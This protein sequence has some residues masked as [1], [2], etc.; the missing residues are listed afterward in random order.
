MSVCFE[1][2]CT[3]DSCG[4]CLPYIL[5]ERNVFF[6][7]CFFLMNLNNVFKIFP[8]KDPGAERSHWQWGLS[9]AKSSP[10]LEVFMI[11][12]NWFTRRMCQARWGTG[13]DSVWN[14]NFQKTMKGSAESWQ[15]QTLQHHKQQDQSSCRVLLL[16]I[17]K[18]FCF[19]HWF[20]KLTWCLINTD[21]FLSCY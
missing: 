2:F 9:W 15:V 21:Y 12:K 5:F 3:L 6:K 16:K 1:F 14:R 20:E 7:Y 8:H 19:V 13:C 17:W 4:M 10:Q 18:S 11:L